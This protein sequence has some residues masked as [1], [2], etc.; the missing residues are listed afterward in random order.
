MFDFSNTFNGN[1]ATTALNKEATALI[2]ML[3]GSINTKLRKLFIDSRKR[4]KIAFGGRG[5]GKSWGIAMC[6]ILRC[7]LAPIKV[8]CLRVYQTSLND[9]VYAVI[10]R[11]VIQYGL[12]SHFT[13]LKSEIRCRNGSLIIFKGIQNLTALKS[14]DEIDIC[15]IE[16]AVGTGKRKQLETL[17][18]EEWEVLTPSIRAKDS[19]IWVSYNPVFEED[20]IH[21]KFAKFALESD[22]NYY[23]DD[24]LGILKTNFDDNIYFTGS[25]LELD[26]IADRGLLSYNHKWLGECICSTEGFPFRELQIDDFDYKA[27][28]K[29]TLAFLDPSFGGADFHGL[30]IL[31]KRDKHYYLMVKGFHTGTNNAY[32]DLIADYQKEFGFTTLCVESNNRGC[33]VARAIQHKIKKLRINVY[34]VRGDKYDRIVNIIAPRIYDITVHAHSDRLINFKNFNKAATHD[35]LEDASASV[36]MLVDNHAENERM[37]NET[38]EALLKGML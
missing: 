17:T 10:K 18:E 22:N 8:L 21:A 14:I 12:E 31:W 11:L 33:D 13:F 27:L 23:T 15:W 32:L 35:D 2:A 5:S 20:F 25:T 29:P 9:S 30:A 38:D 24:R 1:S 19:E 7:M 34:A 16:E 37:Y 26:E 3:Y 6:I 28:G 36:I 4:I